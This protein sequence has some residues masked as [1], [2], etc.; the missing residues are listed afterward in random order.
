[1]TVE[2]PLTKIAARGYLG[3]V[4][5]VYPRS[6]L[7]VVR[8]TEHDPPVPPD[9]LGFPQVDVLADKLVPAQKTTP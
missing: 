9:V 7:V 1:M 5:L 3:Q 6:R 2:G 8:M 4:M